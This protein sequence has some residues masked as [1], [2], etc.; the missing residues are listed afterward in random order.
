MLHSVYN[1]LYEYLKHKIERRARVDSTPALYSGGP[2]FKSRPGDRLTEVI[3]GY[4]LDRLKDS[5]LH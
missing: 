3:P 5:T 4:P 1:L 2:G